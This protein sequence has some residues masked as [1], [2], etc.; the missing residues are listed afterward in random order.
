MVG[1][2]PPGDLELAVF[3]AVI[4]SNAHYRVGGSPPQVRHSPFCSGDRPPSVEAA[5][6]GTDR[7]HGVDA[8]WAPEVH[9]EPQRSPRPQTR[10]SN[11]LIRRPFPVPRKREALPKSGAAPGS[12][13]ATTEHIGYM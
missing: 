3:A 4:L 8:D 6:T 11:R 13:G 9:A 2:E 10:T 5:A 12:Q 1:L 7:E